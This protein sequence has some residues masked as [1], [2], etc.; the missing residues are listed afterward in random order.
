MSANKNIF[1][2][3]N[4]DPVIE[5]PDKDAWWVTVPVYAG[6]MLGGSE[7]VM[8]YVIREI[9]NRRA[10]VEAKSQHML[11]GSRAM[12]IPVPAHDISHEDTE[13][14]FDR[15]EIIATGFLAEIVNGR[16]LIDEKRIAIFK[17][18]RVRRSKERL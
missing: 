7:W 13:S 8:E 6:L 16:V 17:N 5:P 9:Q 10:T 12:S 1:A 11:K 4:G 15:A 3:Y 2:K 18:R 14:I